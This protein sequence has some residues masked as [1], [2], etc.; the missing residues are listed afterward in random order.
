MMSLEQMPSLGVFGDLVPELSNMDT[1]RLWLLLHT[2][3]YRLLIT[4]RLL[5]K[6]QAGCLPEGDDLEFTCE[7]EEPWP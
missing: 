1:Y 2:D 5:K 3:R 4:E 7:A 6:L